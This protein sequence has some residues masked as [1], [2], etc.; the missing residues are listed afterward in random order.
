MDVVS[1]TVSFTSRIAGK[2]PAAFQVD[3]VGID[4]GTAFTPVDKLCMLRSLENGRATE[5][6]VSG[7]CPPLPNPNPNPVPRGNLAFRFVKHLSVY[8]PY[9]F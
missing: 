1:P 8:T 5:R 6:N 4:P 7:E 9:A 3:F 2:Q